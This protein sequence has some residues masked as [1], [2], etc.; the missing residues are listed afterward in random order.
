METG[1]GSKIKYYFKNYRRIFE[2]FFSL[3]VLNAISFLFPLITVPF[4]TRVLGP[5]TFG[6]VSFATVVIQ[7][8]I[9]FTS[10]GF[11]YS[12][13]QQI[14]IHQA[15][16]KK[17]SDIFSA[18]I[19]VK[20]IIS[21]ICGVFLLLLILFFEQFRS[22]YLIFIYSFGVVIGDALVP[23]WL[24]QGMEKMKFITLVNFVSKLIFTLLIFVFVRAE[25]DYLIVPLFNT[26]GYLIAGVIS[27][28]IAY[29]T[30]KLDIVHP[31]F[32]EI[33]IQFQEAWPIFVSTFSMN[34]YRNANVLLLGLFTNY[35]IVGFYSSAEKVIRGMQSIISP[36]SDALFPFISKKFIKESTSRNVDFML[37]LGKYYFV[38]L[39]AISLIFVLF[40]GP[41][42]RG[43]LGHKFVDSI[44]D[45][46]IM[47]F[48]ILF[49]GMNYFLGIVGLVNMGYKKTFMIFV[50]I[51][52][53]ISIINLVCLI[54][55]FSDQGA[56]ASML[57]SEFILFMM[58]SIFIFKL[59]KEN[60]QHAG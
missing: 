1:P 10:F 42:V 34:L 55:F 48:V 43:F 16:K 27:F 59:K 23:V 6:L 7:Y 51:T 49:G 53:L 21:V 45:M 11:A 20:L 13:T 19:T 29:R 31:K 52:G 5:T 32:S 17:I 58:L 2:N 37:R 50:A 60:G 14:S 4:L 15:N 41:I 38:V 9:I 22:N 26:C 30:F 47:G 54:H 24:F 57:I 33:K 18:V 28:V 44:P 8:F 36:V 39:T 35:T 40:S 46:Q 3:S 25:S 12:A 56:S